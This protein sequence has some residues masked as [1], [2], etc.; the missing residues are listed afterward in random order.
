[1]TEKPSTLSTKQGRQA[2]LEHVLEHKQACAWQ[3]RQYHVSLWYDSQAEAIK[4]QKKSMTGLENRVL[5]PVDV[6]FSAW[7]FL[8]GC[9]AGYTSQAEATSTEGTSTSL[10]PS[11]LVTTTQSRYNFFTGRHTVIVTKQYQ[12]KPKPAKPWLVL[13]YIITGFFIISKIVGVI[14]G[15]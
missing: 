2:L 12:E 11:V 13:G 4:L 7:Q 8:Q 1:M 14:N 6:P 10:Q 15:Y 9:T 3:G 5:Q